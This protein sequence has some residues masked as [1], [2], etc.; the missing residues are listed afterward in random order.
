M[1]IEQALQHDL[2]KVG[3]SAASNEA[4]LPHI[5]LVLRISRDVL[6]HA[7]LKMGHEHHGEWDELLQEFSKRLMPAV[8]RLADTISR[9]FWTT[10]LQGMQDTLV[11]LENI[12]DRSPLA[13]YEADI[14]GVITWAN[15][16]L[17]KLLHRSEPLVGVRLNDVFAPVENGG[18]L[19][20][21]FSESSGG[22]HVSLLVHVP[23]GTPVALEI[24]TIM[25]HDV[26]GSIVG[27]AG[28][29]QPGL[30]APA[31]PEIPAI[32]E[33]APVVPDTTELRQAIGLLADA[34]KFLRDRSESLTPDLI[35]KAG[36]SLQRQAGRLVAMIDQLQA[37]E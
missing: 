12:V 2:E 28:V 35:G 1:E 8:D 30:S 9:G 7:M 18:S 37:S 25:R 5:L 27:F 36:D 32:A 31:V 17:G 34:G 33:L 14:D 19:S 16:M 21:L 23:D 29:V 4:S 26:E 15:P 11:K 24:D 10:K 22:S 13:M 3:A 20:G 6:L